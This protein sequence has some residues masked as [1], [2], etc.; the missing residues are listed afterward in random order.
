MNVEQIGYGAGT[1]NPK[2]FPNVLRLSIG[3]LTT[4]S[5]A[6]SE[7]ATSAAGTS[8]AANAKHQTVAVLETALDDA[9]P[10]LLAYVAEQVLAHGALDVMLTPVLMKKGRPG[11]LLTVLASPEHSEALQQLIL[12]E[13]PTL[14]YVFATTNAR[15]SPE[16]TK[17][18]KPPTAPSA[19]S[20]VSPT[21]KPKTPRQNT[22]TVKPQPSDTTS[23]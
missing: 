5:V 13:T 12:R 22:K 20:S 11:T 10:Q 3:E 15:S 18:S 1:R 19:S 21:T 4:G 2:D 16:S 8:E 23:P 9:T 7:A 6:T 17:L 14:A